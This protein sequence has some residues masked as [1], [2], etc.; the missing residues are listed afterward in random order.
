MATWKEDIIQALKNLGG[1]AHLKEIF[2]EVAR[3]RKGKLNKTW[4]FGIQ[5][6]LQRFSSDSIYGRGK[7]YGK[8]NVEDIFEM[9][10]GK[11]KGVWG[12]RNYKSRIKSNLKDILKNI[13]NNWL[14]YRNHCKATSKIGA[15]IKIVKKDHK[16]FDLVI[17]QWSME[18]KRIMDLNKYNVESSVGK[19]NLSGIPWLAIMDKSVTETAREG[20]YVVYLFS[21]SAKKLFL[22]IGIGADQFQSIYGISNKALEKQ[23]LATKQFQSLFEEY[24]PKNLIN[25][26]DLL[27]DDVDFEEPFKGSMRHLVS[28]Y[29][30]GTCF[31]KEYKIDELNNKILIEDLI[32]FINSYEGIIKDPK[33]TG[34]DIIAET[35]ISSKKNVEETSFNYEIPTFKPREKNKKIKISTVSQA[36][37]KRNTQQS[38]KVGDAGEEHVYLYEYDKLK[39]LD[40]ENLSKQIVKHYDLYEFVGWDIT[41]YDKDGNEI[42]IEVKSTRG[43]ELNSIGIT[44][45]EWDAAKKK[46]DKYYIYLVNNALNEKVKIFEKIKNP[47][48]LVEK[49]EIDIS[50]L[51]YELK[52]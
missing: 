12:L 17:N 6:T 20:F 25:K 48:K 31:A 21:R 41:S 45:N 14:D 30:K 42:Y 13:S 35:F 2:K 43:K 33:S 51:T 5:E 27:E 52:L 28:A 4:T 44:R 15:K 18:I 26:I 39:K 34:L 11:G 22:S 23:E 19:G 29:E 49:K 7:A 46:G 3:L 37:N 10:E 32:E 47:A 50:T 36:K 24:K 9:V 16:F 40:L 38:K 8:A 1:S